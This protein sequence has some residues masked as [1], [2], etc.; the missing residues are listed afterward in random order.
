MA[1]PFE[2]NDYLKII[3]EDKKL[4]PDWVRS[5]FN[6]GRKQVYTDRKALE[7]I[8]MPVGGI[9]A[10]TVYLSGDGRLWLWDIFNR[11]QEGILPTTVTY[12]G[13]S[14]PS[15]N[16]ARY[17]KPAPVT[18]PFEQEF[19]MRVT[20]NGVKKDIPLNA[21][22]FEAVSFNGQYPLGQVNY[23]SSRLPLKAML[24][25]YSPFIPLN[26][27]DSSLPATLMNY[28]ISNTSDKTI[29]VNLYGKLQNP[30]CMET[31]NWTSGCLVNTVVRKH[32]FSAIHCFAEP[33]KEPGQLRPDIVFED[34]EKDTYDGW[35]VEGGAFGRSPVK[36]KDMP[37]YQGDVAGKNERVVNSHASAPGRDIAAKDGA[38]GALTSRIFTV[39]RNYI[40][41]LIGGGSHKGQ[42]CM[43]LLI[44]GEIAASAT[45]MNNNRMSAASFDVRSWQD[46]TA[47]LQIIDEVAGTWGNIGVDQI[48]FTDQPIRC[49]KL[50]EQRDYGSMS[51]ALFGSRSVD[52]AAAAEG[53]NQDRVVG[54]LNDK[55]V[56][57]IGTTLNLEPGQSQTISFAITWNF[58]NFYA[59]GID[60]QLVGHSY[61]AR[62]TTALDVTKYIAENFARLTS[63]TQKW[64]DAWYDSTL[65]YWLLDRTMANTS[66]LATTTCY[67]FKDGRFWAWEG[68]GCCPGTCTHVWHY[69]QAPGRIFPE[70]ERIEREWVNFGLGQ[71]SD[72]G[73]GM[74]AN[75]SGANEPAHDGQ[76]GRILGAYRDHQMSADD[77]FLQRIWPNIKKAIAFLIQKDG[78]DDGRIEGA[79]PNTL[80]AEWFGKISFLQSLYIAALKAGQ[81]MAAEMGDTEFAIKCE[82]IAK[83]GAETIEELFNGEYFIQIEDPS[84]KK[85][86]GVGPGC[87]ID[88]VFGQSWA[89]QVGLGHIFDKDK[90]L[91]ALRFLWKYNFVPDVGLFRDRFKQ[92]R[93]Y[94]MPGDAG[95][96]MCTWPQGGQNPD[97]DKH[98]QY[99]YF[100][101]CM[102]GFEWQVASH[103][104][105]EGMLKEGLAVGRAIHDRYD[106]SL[107]NPYNEIE[108]S[109]HY[110]R[111][112]ASYG[113]FIS[114]C[115]FQH[116]GPKGYL[117]FCP[118]TTPEDFKAPFITAEGWGTF[119]QQR[120][121][122]T[123]NHLIQLHWG[124]LKL[125]QMGFD[126]PT[127]KTAKK[128]GVKANG[129]KI[130]A[131]Y[132]MAENRIIVLF[133][134]PLQI[135]AG[136]E[137]EIEI[138][139]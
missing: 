127:G 49:D 74:R 137:M 4:S 133:D 24:K 112:M 30:V 65:P 114:I 85:E 48:V 124:C 118:R 13:N 41:F 77:A 121:G 36:I 136:Q 50:T 66:T 15:R 17:I 38:V 88:Q 56:G 47:Q 82:K 120:K 109:D 34:F 81:A 63:Q 86:I 12:K 44:N 107:R 89:H 69:A 1:G 58:P 39:E 18:I 61:A 10:G 94:A 123:Q 29:E 5:L 55:L 73:I 67:R 76:C 52:Y 51:L 122:K 100:N 105:C 20:I 117:A 130:G 26:L 98:W 108:C 8:G 101:E 97:F 125:K 3:T 53:M 91:R 16:G 72:G 75:L 139:C 138:L 83:R 132:R 128:I 57:T 64:V 23:E 95:L 40:V 92:G 35:T 78:N 42:T 2:D 59:R 7:H 14:V 62:F 68:I 31:R 80:D 84:R 104:I 102:S 90:Q 103:M 33:M 93:W 71:H 43:N 60:G 9:F 99:M 27:D 25:A 22:G 116:H 131:S 37:D 6:R 46:K 110:A 111:A 134:K 115:G 96:V 32:D 113:V 19:G 21:D 79:Q 45:G 119:V 126:L 11:D 70:I 54:N 28:T 106:A 135:E 129:R 87:Y